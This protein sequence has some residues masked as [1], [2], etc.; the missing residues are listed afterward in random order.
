MAGPWACHQLNANTKP[1]D[2]VYGTFTNVR[3]G[4]KGAL[5]LPLSPLTHTHTHTHT[6]IRARALRVVTRQKGQSIYR[7]ISSSR[8]EGIGGR[9]ALSSLRWLVLLSAASPSQK[10]SQPESLFKSWEGE[11]MGDGAKTISFSATLHQSLSKAMI[12]LEGGSDRTGS[13]CMC[14]FYFFRHAGVKRYLEWQ[15]LFGHPARLSPPVGR[16]QMGTAKV[17]FSLSSRFHIW[18]DTANVLVYRAYP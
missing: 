5:S 16:S 11:E 2:F 3:T 9:K 1:S 17:S 6:Y 15:D 8:G 10:A 13:K 7:W 4:G 18:C 12:P 14:F